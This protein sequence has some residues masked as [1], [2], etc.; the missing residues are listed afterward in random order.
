MASSNGI[1]PELNSQ[2]FLIGAIYDSNTPLN[3]KNYFHGWI[4]EVRIWKTA[5]T[6]EQLHFMMNQ[7]LEGGSGTNPVKGDVL[8]L[9][10]PSNLTWD[11]LDGYYQLMGNQVTGGLTL[12]KASV[13]I[14]G[15]VKNVITI[16]ENTAPLPYISNSNGVWTDKNTWRLPA[17]YNGQSLTNRDVWDIPNST[18]INNNSI[19]WN[20]VNAKNDIT[21]GEKNI[22]LLGLISENG[23]LLIGN[24]KENYNWQNSGQSL[25]ITHYLKLNG[26][27]NLSGESQLVQTDKDDSNTKQTIVSILDSTSTGFIERSQQGTASGFNY[28]YWSSPV[29]SQGNANNS[30]Y[31]VASVMMDGSAGTNYGNPLS[32]NDWYE[33]ADYAYGNDAP[34]RI[35]NYWLYKF[36]GT[37]NVYSEWE[38]V[39]STGTLLAGEGYTMKGT[40]G[41][42][43]IPHRQNYIFKGKPNN[44]TINLDIGLDQNYLLGNPYPS[45]ISIKDFILDNLN[46]N[47]VTGATNTKNIFNGAVYFWDH[48]SG[49]THILAEYIGGY[50]TA[51]IL[52]ATPAVA[53]DERINATGGFGKTPGYYIPVA[54]GFFINTVLHPEFSDIIN[55]DGGDVIFKNSQRVYVKETAPKDSQ[56]L[57]PENPAKENKQAHTQAKI[58]LD[59]RSPTGYNRQIL[60]GSDPNTTN[61]F[62]LGYDAPLNDNNLEDMFWLINN[63]EF[64]I[65]GVPNFGIDQVLPLGIKINETG[66]FSIKINKTENVAEDVNIYLNDLQDST[67]FDLRKSDYSMNLDQGNYYERFQ[68]VFQK[69][70]VSTEEPDPDEET[71]EEEEQE[72]GSDSGSGEEEEQ[73]TDGTAGEEEILDKQIKVF[74]IG[75]NRE[76]VIV[77]P[78]KFEI[79]RV[80]IYDMLGQIIQEYQNISDEKEVR[81][82]VRE[83]PAAVYAIKLFSGNKEISKSIILIR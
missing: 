46:K 62:D 34:R 15:Q 48:F 60:V 81:L 75:N 57:Q 77:N 22:T 39:G 17:N 44:G 28:N 40:S 47:I 2:P 7:R 45:A 64:V 21:S 30:T 50:A 58:R 72:Q 24:P 78:S 69:E 42:A 82:P 74:Y 36:R 32:F 43:A 65:Q 63:I 6:E 49:K 51:N 1:N 12:D 26:A 80:I 10:V 33:Y 9:Q 67:Y 68:I 56:F 8:P 35:S 29:V 59:F 70:K 27:I 76:I 14:D 16:Q 19:Q 4:E 71:E 5:L 11:K 31:T 53:T 23:Q 54:Q 73:G 61:G 20:I 83:F 79:E 41:S 3:P 37:S 25:T 38:R 13:K 55:V 52:G 66:E 18:G